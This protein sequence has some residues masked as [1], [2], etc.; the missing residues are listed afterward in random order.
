MEQVH[1]TIKDKSNYRHIF[2]STGLFGGVQV[3]LIVAS[4]FKA[5]FAALFLGAAGMGISGLLVSS[6]SLIQTIA[7]LGLN[8]SAVR[9]ISKA[10]ETE[11]ISKLSFSITIF[12]RW[13]FL[14]ASL[15]LVLIL[16]LSPWLSQFVFGNRE[17][18]TAYICLSVMVGLNIL[19][20]GYVTM[21]QGTR[22]L[23][24]VAT[25]SVIGAVL[26]V[27]IM[28]PIYYFFRIKGIVPALICSALVSFTVSYVFAK[29]IKL[30]HFSIGLRKTISEGSE[31]V[32]LGIV[33]MM[34]SL[35]GTLAIL[36]IN[37][38]IKRTGSLSDVGLYQAG[39][40]ITNQSLGLVFSAMSVDYFPRLAAV[41]DNSKKVRGLA[42][43]QS[44]IML[45]IV[46]PIL[47]M[48]ILSTPVIIRILLS[49][50]FLPVINFVRLISLGMFFQAAQYSMGLISFA[51]GDKKTFLLLGIQG[52][53]QWLLFSVLGYLFHGLY[54]ISVLF[55]FHSILCYI[56]TY[57]VVFRKYNYLMSITFVRLFILSLLPIVA[58]CM[59]VIILPNLIGYSISFVILCCS[60]MY[61][62]FKLN[63]L[64]GLKDIF[65]GIVNRFKK[66]I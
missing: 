37:T 35:M 61:S 18:T 44:E 40:S 63:D 27:L 23:T 4:M 17:Y 9:E 43:Q 59:L 34:T 45:L 20:G 28:I 26:S 38:F 50:E 16:V 41:S 24:D 12:R 56:I 6:L 8:T 55:V 65:Y 1:A 19:G 54:G 51:K 46:T 64:I 5:K 57:Y 15:G 32:K 52:N 62:I 66:N 3:I 42:N 31:M 21:L 47:L 22:R 39:M 7:G 10:K 11:D 58:M 33:M 2:K 36:L 49:K 14:T 29:K 13:Q 60:I 30:I 53:A 48:I 25:S